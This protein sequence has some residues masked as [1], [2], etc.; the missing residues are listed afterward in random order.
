MNSQIFRTESEEETIR[1]GERLAAELPPHATLLLIGDLGAGKTTLT[2][3][4]VKG[5]G[6]GV[7]EDVSSPTF[8]LIHEYS[9]TRK[10]YHIDLYRIEQAGELDSLGLDEIFEQEAIVLIEWGERF[11]ERMPPDHI[12][13]WIEELE[14]NAR[15]IEVRAPRDQSDSSRP[16]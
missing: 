11:L 4:L 8:T 14:E 1:L 7:P 12:Q 5:L 2:K 6:A 15:R 9:G 13:I 3:G 16:T 10:V